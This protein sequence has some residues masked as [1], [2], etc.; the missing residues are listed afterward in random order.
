MSQ[1]GEIDLA[2][3]KA[4]WHL[5]DIELVNR[6]KVDQANEDRLYYEVTSSAGLMLLGVVL[7]KFNWP[8]FICSLMFLGAAVFFLVKFVLKFKR[9]SSYPIEGVLNKGT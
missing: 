9:L 1:Q 6:D 3:L 7:S 2:G 4:K 8:F 5:D